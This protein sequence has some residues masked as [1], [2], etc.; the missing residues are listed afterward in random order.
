MPK[1]QSGVRFIVTNTW[2]EKLAEALEERGFKV[3]KTKRRSAKSVKDE[4]I[5]TNFDERS[6]EVYTLHD[7]TDTRRGLREVRQGFPKEEGQGQDIGYDAG[8]SKGEVEEAG[9]ARVSD[10]IRD[11]GRGRGGVSLTTP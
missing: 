7:T 4:L 8:K 2:D 11:S 10:E 3:L 5:T 6:G 1:A 9:S